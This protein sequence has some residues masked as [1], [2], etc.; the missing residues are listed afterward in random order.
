MYGK[1]V[2]IKDNGEES[3][4]KFTTTCIHINNKVVVDLER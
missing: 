3:V 4:E 1:S 2:H